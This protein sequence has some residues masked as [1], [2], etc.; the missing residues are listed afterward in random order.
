MSESSFRRRIAV[1][2]TALCLSHLPRALA[3]EQESGSFSARPSDYGQGGRKGESA[4]FQGT[5]TSQEVGASSQT[6]T[7]FGNRAGFDGW[8][9]QPAKINDVLLAGRHV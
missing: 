4:S 9:P 3:G 6:S 5:G 2:A 1:L 8:T 7:S